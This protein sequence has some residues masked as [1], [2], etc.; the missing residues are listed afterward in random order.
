MDIKSYVKGVVLLAIVQYC[1]YSVSGSL[2][3]SASNC[4]LIWNDQTTCN[5]SADV[6]VC[7]AREPKINITTKLDEVLIECFT[8]DNEAYLQLPLKNISKIKKVEFKECPL[9]ASGCSIQA[10]LDRLGINNFKELSLNSHS[11]LTRQHLQGLSNIEQLNIIG[12]TDLAEDLFNDTGNLTWFILRS[13]N[14]HLPLNIFRNLE[15]LIHLD[16]GMN[17]LKNLKRGCFS[18]QKLLKYLFLNNNDLQNLNK[19]VFYGL[20][21]MSHL[22]LSSN[23][24]V[25]L[26]SDVFSLLE[27]MRELN[28]NENYFKSLSI[29]LLNETKKLER[30]QLMNNHVELSILPAELFANSPQLRIVNLECGLKNISSNF[31]QGLYNIEYASLANNHLETLPS[32]LFQ[33]MEA[34][35]FI[36]LKHNKLKHLDDGLFERTNKLEKLWLSHNQL[37]QI[38]AQVSD[39]ILIYFTKVI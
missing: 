34:V 31:F 1:W 26:D 33:D 17:N 20:S 16:L 7:P 24:L 10:I 29:G 5:D 23:K 6:L 2:D 27:N 30:F 19:D 18:H 22:D 8:M 28:L 36:N 3:H 35:S 4:S 14:V 12:T 32:T 25:T 21:S 11:T 37:E 15:K 9:P 38:S 39:Q 13:K